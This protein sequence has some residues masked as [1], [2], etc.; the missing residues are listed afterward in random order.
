MHTPL[1]KFQRLEIDW[2]LCQRVER[3]GA[4][5]CFTLIAQPPQLYYKQFNIIKKN[6]EHTSSCVQWCLRQKK[7][8]VSKL[9]PKLITVTG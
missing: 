1:Q 5:K 4:S 8:T 2:A 6:L 9:I 3:N 7:C